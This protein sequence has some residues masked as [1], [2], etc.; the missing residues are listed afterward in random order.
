ME[1]NIP[2]ESV[3]AYTIYNLLTDLKRTPKEFEDIFWSDLDNIL[4]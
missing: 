2:N 1:K 4:A 3:T